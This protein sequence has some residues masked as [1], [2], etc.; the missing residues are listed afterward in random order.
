[1]VPDRKRKSGAW[2]LFAFDWQQG[3]V[4]EDAFAAGEG[5]F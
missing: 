2:K 5:R 1:M 4:F 3:S